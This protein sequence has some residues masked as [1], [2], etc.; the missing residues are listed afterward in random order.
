MRSPCDRVKP[1]DVI[2]KKALR[3]RILRDVEMRALWAA[4][5][6]MGYPYGP[7]IRLLVLTG[8]RKSEVS[9][10]RWSEFDL[11]RWLWTIPAERMKADAPHTVPLTAEAVAV[12]ESLPRFQNGGYLFSTTLGQKPV[13]GFSKAKIRLDE[14][15]SA[16]LRNRVGELGIVHFEPWTIHDIRRTVRTGLSALP[17]PDLVRELVIAHAKPGLHKVY[18]QY[19]YL[20]EKRR[21]LELWETRLL[22]IVRSAYTTRHNHDADNDAGVLKVSGRT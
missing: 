22:E 11:Q 9:D 4:T 8:Q 20:D 15:L 18:D 2:G 10:A 17:I 19:A 14:F 5:E 21:A 3:T 12:L 16:E 7:L 6:S 1:K 13:S